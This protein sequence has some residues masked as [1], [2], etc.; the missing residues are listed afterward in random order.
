MIPCGAGNQ[1]DF[2]SCQSSLHC[3]SFCFPASIISRIIHFQK[4]HR[5]C[6]IWDQFDSFGHLNFSLC[7][8]LF[9]LTQANGASLLVRGGS[10]IDGTGGAPIA[11][12]RILITDG[13]IDRVWSG[14]T[15]APALPAGKQIVE[16]GGKVIIPGIIDSQVHYN[17]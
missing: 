15:G 5:G 10:L 11:N 16:A 9:A 7:L 13:R 2:S 12:A 14:D 6:P 1:H 8:L 17:L 3:F 4:K